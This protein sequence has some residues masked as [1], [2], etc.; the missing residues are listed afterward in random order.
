MSI[1]AGKAEE[2]ECVHNRC[3]SIITFS[4]SVTKYFSYIIWLFLRKMSCFRNGIF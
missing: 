2:L 1:I 4:L 3:N